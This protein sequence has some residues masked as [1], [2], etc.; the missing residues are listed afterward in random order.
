MNAKLVG[1]AVFGFFILMHSVAAVQADVETN[2]WPDFSPVAQKQF[3]QQVGGD[4]YSYH[5]PWVNPAAQSLPH[6]ASSMPAPRTYVAPANISLRA[7]G[8]NTLPQTRLESFVK[9]SGMREDIYGM[10]GQT[11]NKNYSPVASGFYG[12][13]AE[14]LTTGHQSDAPSVYE[15]PTMAPLQ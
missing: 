8:R 3:V 9:A 10:D 5:A 15:F 1:K 7:L 6:T 4:P 12:E 11:R 13:T 14:G 2:P